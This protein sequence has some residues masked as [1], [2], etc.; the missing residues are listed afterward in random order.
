MKKINVKQPFSQC[1]RIGGSGTSAES[2][3][4]PQNGGFHGAG[5]TDAEG[6]RFRKAG[7][8]TGERQRNLLL[9][10]TALDPRQHFPWADIFR[11]RGR[12]T[13][14]LF[15]YLWSKQRISEGGKRG[16]LDRNPGCPDHRSD[17]SGGTEC[18]KGMISVEN[19]ASYVLYPAATP[20]EAYAIADIWYP[21]M[22]ENEAKTAFCA[23]FCRRS[24]RRRSVAASA[25]RITI[26]WKM[27]IP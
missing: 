15:L 20:E 14:E 24:A 17:L 4:I 25:R 5:D 11:W 10:G 26:M 27:S 9:P 21:G 22:L 12:G 3:R 8:G 19:P 13:A 7:R 16:W 23:A 18:G 1:N 2:H 6:E